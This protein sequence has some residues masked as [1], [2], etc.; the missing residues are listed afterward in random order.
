MTIGMAD[1]DLDGLPPPQAIEELAFESIL[2]EL[3]ADFRARWPDWDMGALETD[4]ILIALQVAAYREQNIRERINEAVR[5]NILPFAIG[6]DLDQ[7]AVF[8][9]VVRLEGESDAQFR[10]RVVLAIAGRSPGGTAERYRSIALSADARIADVVVWT[11][12]LDPYVRVSVLNTLNNGVPYPEMLTAVREAL[13]AS[14][15]LMVNDTLIVTGAVKT[16]VDVAAD[17]WLLPNAPQATLDTLA[18]HLRDAWAAEG[19]LGRDLTPSWLVARLMRPG[20]ARVDVAAP[21]NGAAAEFYE[22]IALGAITLT[23][24]GRA[25]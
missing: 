18:Q 22:A 10:R 1:I 23:D 19:G 7:L 24:K 15:V 16:M 17:V 3:V 21:M 2:A 12:P 5:S 6:G 14:G 13:N 4:P 20:V 9:D 8:Y 11:N 25:Y